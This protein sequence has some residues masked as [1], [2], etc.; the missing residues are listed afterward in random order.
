MVPETKYVKT[1][2]GVHIAYQVFGDGPID[3]ACVIGWMT[4]IEAMWDEPAFARMLA[5]LGSFSRVILFDKRGCGLSDR[6]PV[7]ELA[8][9]ETRM[10]DIRAVMDAAGSERAVVFGV[11]EGGPMAMLF[12]ATHPERT[13]ALAVCRQPLE[14]GARQLGAGR[15]AS[16]RWRSSTVGDGG[17]ARQAF[18]DWAA[19]SLADDERAVRWLAAYTRR[20]Q[21][22]EPP[23]P[24]EHE[25]VH[26]RGRRP[27]VD[28]RAD[29]RARPDRRR[30]SSRSRTSGS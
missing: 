25:L 4:N 22:P 9:L 29:H 2:D 14:L 7:N 15:A 6:V 5:Q 27:L 28:P 17:V 16:R 24:R 30:S 8:S 18:A 26:R 19:P 12:A 3:L 20:P 23:S 11:S 21:A 13:I 1:P 10:D